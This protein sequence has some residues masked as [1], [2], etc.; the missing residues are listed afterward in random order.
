MWVFFDI[1]LWFWDL[2][3]SKE[4]SWKSFIVFLRKRGVSLKL[5]VEPSAHS[6]GRGVVLCELAEKPSAC[7]LQDQAIPLKL[8]G[9]KP[10]GC[11]SCK[12]FELSCLSYKLFKL[13]EYD[14]FTLEKNL[15]E[16]GS[17]L[18]KYF[19]SILPTGTPANFIFENDSLSSCTLITKWTDLTKG[20]LEY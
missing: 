14:Y 2:I 16:M 15:W 19:E 1:S 3:I 17:Q 8:V 4:N 10:T 12:L 13:F 5:P 9:I 7:L 18:S 6:F 20:N 11:L